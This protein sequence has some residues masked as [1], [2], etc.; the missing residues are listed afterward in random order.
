M[1]KRII[2]FG[3]KKTIKKKEFYSDDN[4]KIFNIND[5]DINKILISKRIFS[6]IINF[7]EY[8][9]GYKHYQI[10]KPLYIKSPEYVC[11]GNTFKK[12]ADFF[13]KYNKYGK[14]WRTN[15]NKFW[16]KTT[17]L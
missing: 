1:G 17:I 4:R 9:I 6:E 7:N 11:R 5:I 3:E 16:R 14:N 10:I 13:E 8:I 2:D 12:N 15:G